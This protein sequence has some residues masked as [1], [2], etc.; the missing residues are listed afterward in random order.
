M[1]VLR[2]LQSWRG[3]SFVTCLVE[4]QMVTIV[5]GLTLVG[6]VAGLDKDER[7]A[8]IFKYVHRS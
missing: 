2:V 8:P 4:P 5:G 7:K 6:C 1:E 3:S